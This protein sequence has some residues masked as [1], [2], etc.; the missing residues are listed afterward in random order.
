[1]RVV[2]ALAATCVA[3]LLALGCQSA[4]SLPPI[5]LVAG[6][7]QAERRAAAEPDRAIRIDA[8]RT[9]RGIEAGVFMRAPARLIYT[10]RLPQR[11]RFVAEVA[12]ALS[13]EPASG[14]TVRMGI[15]D[16]RRY[17]ELLVQR[18][19]PPRE[20]VPTWA[21]VDIDLAP[22]SGWQWS[23][24]YRP[25]VRT[26]RVIL[27]ADATP[28]GTLVWAAPRIIFRSQTTIRQQPP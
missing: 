17:T 6:L 10:A 19:D 23:V 27:N 1:M 26:W 4:S 13:G 11:A 3:Q 14:V 21:P 15:S 16:G 25:A 22:Y 2:L 28:G 8:V 9:V 24:F 18:L 20:G 5:D 12:E 7:P